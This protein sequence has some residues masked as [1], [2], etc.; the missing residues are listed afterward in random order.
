MTAR[1]RAGATRPAEPS[2]D[3]PIPPAEMP[4]DS[5]E[6]LRSPRQRPTGWAWLVLRMCVYVTAAICSQLLLHAYE[7]WVT[8]D[9]E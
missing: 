2:G 7:R 8:S 1:K 5:S 4:A 6:A 3:V 9:D